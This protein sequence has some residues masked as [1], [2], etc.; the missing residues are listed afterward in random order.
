MQK[1]KL[2]HCNLFI[3][4]IFPEPYVLSNQGKS[5]GSLRAEIRVGIMTLAIEIGWFSNIALSSRIRGTKNV[6][7]A[8]R[9]AV[10]QFSN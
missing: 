10:S 1:S 9:F 3:S 7:Y 4:E 2:R 8:S 5:E 6:L